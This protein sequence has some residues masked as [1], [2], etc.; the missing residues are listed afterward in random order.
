MAYSGKR[1]VDRYFIWGILLG[2]LIVVFK[3]SI[4]AESPVYLMD[5]DAIWSLIIDN[6]INEIP[7][8][9]EAK[10][11]CFLRAL[12]GGLPY[13]LHDRYS[14]YL[15]PHQ[16]HEESFSRDERFVGVGLEI[17]PLE[18]KLIVLSIMAASPALECGKL[19]KG[20]AI[21]RI[22]GKDVQDKPLDFVISKLRGDE[23]TPVSIQVKRNGVIQDEVTLIRKIIISASVESESISDNIGYIKISKFND[24]TPEEFLQEALKYYRRSSAVNLR[25]KIII[26]LR[27]NP[28]GTLNSA[29][30]VGMF[31]AKSSDDIIVT[32]K[33]RLGKINNITVRG[34]FSGELSSILFFTGVLSESEIV[35]LVNQ[36]S[37]SSAEI[38]SGVLRDWLNA[39][40]VGKKT[41][42][43]GRVQTVLQLPSGGALILTTDE[44]FVGNNQVKIDGSGLTP[45]YE[46]IDSRLDVLDETLAISNAIDMKNDAQLRKAVALLSIK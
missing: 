30:G 14:S 1:L 21:I 39:S 46:V 2:C 18:N 26:D 41:Y 5:F 35:V 20:D 12:Q 13:C 24:E 37:A 8:T 15:P 19:R 7:N 45:D 40:L 4:T 32:L 28:G 9:E 22:N 17:A 3:V 34:F 44:Y 11:D 23:G 6:Y 27:D 10:R 31:F 29:L 42:G 25:N 38:L 36:E 16:F 33:G 43:K